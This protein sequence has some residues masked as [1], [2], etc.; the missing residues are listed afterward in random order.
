MPTTKHAHL[1]EIDFDL[2]QLG[3]P[4]DG[5][6]LDVLSDVIT[7]RDTATEIL[8][9]LKHLQQVI[10]GHAPTYQAREQFAVDLEETLDTLR[11]QV[12]AIL[13]AEQTVY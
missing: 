7:A 5:D 1:D 10:E 3:E 12:G 2:A 9:H 4:L 6:A 11:A 8:A 13:G